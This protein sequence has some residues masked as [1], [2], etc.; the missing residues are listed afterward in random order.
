M[1]RLL[2]VA[3]FAA[4]CASSSPGIQKE[5]ITRHATTIE[6]LLEYSIRKSSPGVQLSR[7]GGV[8]QLRIRGALEDP[9]YVVDGVPVSGGAGGGP[10][11]IHPNDIED[12]EVVTSLARL[13]QYGIRGARGAVIITTKRQ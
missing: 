10:P 13:A 12:V 3:L 6:E 9:L 5:K 2:I 4:G 1:K 8:L 7:A 11:F